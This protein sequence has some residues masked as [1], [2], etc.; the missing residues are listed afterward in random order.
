MI[1]KTFVAAITSLVVMVSVPGI[2]TGED[3]PA[4]LGPINSRTGLLLT[5]KAII[6][7]INA[8]S[9]DLTHDYV[10]RIALWDRNRMTQGYRE[11]AEWVA[12]KAK[13]FGLEEVTIESFPSG[14]GVRYFGNRTE[15]FWEATRGELW[16]K[17]PYVIKLTS[18]SELPLSLCKHSASAHLETE[19]VDIG[20]GLFESD[21][22]SDVKGKIVLTSSAPEN[23]IQRAVDEKGAA[24][25]LSY[26]VAPFWDYANRQPGDFPSQVGWATLRGSEIVP[27]EKSTGLAPPEKDTFAFLISAHRAK[28]LKQLMQQGETIRLR[29]DVDTETRPGTLDVVSGIIRGSKY[30]EEEIVLCAHLDHY[31]PGA[32][33]NASGSAC[34][35]EM[36]HALNYLID[37]RQFP[38]P[39]RTIRFLWVPEY[40]GTW[41]WFSKHIDD[42]ITR[43]SALNYDGVGVDLIKA[44]SIFVMMY[45][46]DSTPSFLNA[47]M[48][49]ILDFMNAHNNVRYPKQKDFHII[50]L[51][52]SR[53]RLRGEMAPFSMGSD[54]EVFNNLKIPAVM[55]GAGPDDFYHSQ[56]DTP[57]KVDATQLHRAVFS[58]LAAITTIAYADDERAAD[59]AQLTFIYGKKRIGKESEVRASRLIASL[60]AGNF[61]EKKRLAPKIIAHVYR[62]EQAA[63]RSTTLFSRTPKTRKVIEQ[64]ASLLE[65]AEGI[66]LQNIAEL[67]EIRA[68]ALSV[69]LKEDTLSAT[70]QEAA[71]LFPH[72]KMTYPLEGTTYVYEK[73][74]GDSDLNALKKEFEQVGENVKKMGGSILLL[75]ALRDAPS[76]Y[77]DGTRSI[78]E[79]RDA[80]AVEYIW[81]P[82]ELMKLYFR[83]FEKAGVV[84]ITQDQKNNRP[85]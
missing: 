75:F 52:G 47:V 14:G 80:I 11:A 8:S 6:K 20:T 69:P 17:E 81:L 82:I 53:N 49:S 38:A 66:S 35:L 85:V 7:L 64:I 58:G 57:D 28:E 4:P 46:P 9:G 23:V 63:I 34:L 25:I 44:H 19:L 39:L 54:H 74:E 2:Q 45:T 27:K 15:P 24:G 30:P 67:T 79:I 36:I 32:N 26:F 65:D 18:Y 68:S 40:I 42:P 41:A 21:Y 60:D 50:S 12:Q 13:E 73:L 29:V 1:Q 59:I 83:V 71:R 70:E 78:L 72:R 55:A 84:V 31:K 16:M 10:S 76:F 51:T 56:E 5:D 43:I 37:S 77:A 33:D 62:R 22:L 61:S 48:E 3:P